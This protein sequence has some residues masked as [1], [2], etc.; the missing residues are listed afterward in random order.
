L[1]VIG[2]Q[3][4]V[5]VDQTVERGGDPDAALRLCAA[6]PALQQVRVGGVHQ[7][8]HRRHRAIAPALGNLLPAEVVDA[9]T[10]LPVNPQAFAVERSLRAR[11]RVRQAVLEHTER[12]FEIPDAAGQAA[13]NRRRAD[14]LQLPIGTAEE[15]KEGLHA[16]ITV[17]HD[18]VLGPGKRYLGPGQSRFGQPH[19]ARHLGQ[20]HLKHTV[21]PGPVLGSHVHHRIERPQAHARKGQQQHGCGLQE[22]TVPRHDGEALH[23]NS[24]WTAARYPP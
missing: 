16:R 7:E 19:I 10:L 9:Q 2:V 3:Q 13:R 12:S 11:V 21:D 20:W 23:L 8:P 14:P 1:L 17:H 18:Q 22:W 5:A 24:F 6:Q 4:A 15:Q